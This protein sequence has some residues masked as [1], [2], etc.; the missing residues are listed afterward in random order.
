MYAQRVCATASLSK[1]QDPL[2]SRPGVDC[3]TGTSPGIST[4]GRR[5]T[6]KPRAEGGLRHPQLAQPWD[7]YLIRHLAPQLAQP[8]DGYLIR[9]LPEEG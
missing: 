8:W 7:G 4:R 3:G 2:S 6:G 5:G 1:R 9:H